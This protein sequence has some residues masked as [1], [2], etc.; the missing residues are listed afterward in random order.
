MT[1]EEWLDSIDDLCE[2]RDFCL[3]NQIL[4]DEFYDIFTYDSLEDYVRDDMQYND[5]GSWIQLR[6]YLDD[7]P[8]GYEWYRRNGAFDYE[9]LD[10]YDYEGFRDMVEQYMLEN[11]LFDPENEEDQESSGEA[12]PPQ[13][14][15]WQGVTEE[16]EQELEIPEAGR[17]FALDELAI[18]AP[19]PEH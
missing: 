2:L 13:M 17:I 12:P 4:E 18:C 10:T 19:D 16:P 15:P 5:T 1:R 8:T 9:G 7:I 11:D 6:D 3:E 14:Y